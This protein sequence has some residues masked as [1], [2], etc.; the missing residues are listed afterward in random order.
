[1]RVGPLQIVM[2]F[3][4]VGVFLFVKSSGNDMSNCYVV[5]LYVT[6]IEKLGLLID[7]TRKT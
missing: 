3:Y 1:M 5:D 7:E 4:G 2:C 6:S